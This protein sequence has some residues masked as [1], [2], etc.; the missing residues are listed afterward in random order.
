MAGVAGR[1]GRKSKPTNQ[2]VLAG[3]PGKRKL[4][5]NEPSFTKVTHVDPPDWLTEKASIMWVLVSKELIED[6][7]L[8]VT[9]LHNVEAFCMAYSRWRDAENHINIY[10]AVLVDHNERSY[11]NPSVTVANEALR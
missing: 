9:D 1:S 2:K 10:G 4:N 6:E 7:V 5:T 11:K 3:N 8:A